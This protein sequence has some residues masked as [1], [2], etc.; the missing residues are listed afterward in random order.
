VHVVILHNAVSPGDSIADQDVLLQVGVVSEALTRLGHTW[1]TVPC[2][3][4]LDPALGEIERRRPDVVFNLVESLGGTDRFAHRAPALLDSM[5]VA[6]TGAPTMAL[7]VS[8]RKVLAK[9]L[10]CHGGLPTPEWVRPKGAVLGEPGVLSSASVFHA[11]VTYVVKAFWEHASLDINDDSL[12]CAED[13]G[14]LQVRLEEAAARCGRPCFAE[15]YIEG[16]EFNLSVLAGSDGPEVLPPAEIDFSAFPTDK[17]RIVSYRAKW[18][19]G[20]FEF[21]NTPRRFDFP[22]EDRPLLDQL[23]QM[24]VACWRLFGLRGYARVDYRVD[25][26][27][28]PWI[29]EVNA[30]P[31]LSPDGGFDAAAAQA[32]I[33]FDQTI[34][35]ILEDAL[36]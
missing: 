7:F 19:E 2:T 4:D 6:Y 36:R 17:P 29:L 14:A 21:Q 24:A 9:E 18:E 33:S 23:S 15:R 30:N 27:G 12:V 20:S 3:A 35:R 10:L 26:T 31:C 32:S 11:S 13:E 16:R 1:E 25:A 28:Q 22:P 5:G 8:N 34:A